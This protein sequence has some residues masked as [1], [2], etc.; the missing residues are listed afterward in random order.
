MTGKIFIRNWIV[1]TTIGVSDE[2]RAC[3]QDVVLNIVLYTDF[4]HAAQTDDVNDT[5]S[6]FDLHAK[7]GA[8]LSASS[9]KLIEV[10]ANAIADICLEDSK[11]SQVEVT[12]EK[13]HILSA[14]ESAGVT[15]IKNQV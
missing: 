10:L 5:V 12:V 8:F 13:P 11:V 14:V 2:E 9:F 3:Q 1:R 4:V 7:I 15:L 6:Y